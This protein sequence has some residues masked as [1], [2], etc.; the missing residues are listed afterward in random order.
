[1]YKE[2]NIG[3]RMD[4]DGKIVPYTLIGSAAWF[5]KQSELVDRNAKTKGRES[6][7]K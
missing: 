5:S 3:P 1:M 2:F 7:K 4:N 6:I